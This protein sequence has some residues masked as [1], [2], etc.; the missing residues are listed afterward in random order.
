MLNYFIILIILMGNIFSIDNNNRKESILLIEINDQI[1]SLEIINKDKNLV[2]YYPLNK[3]LIDH[4]AYKVE[5]WNSSA[6]DNDI[7]NGIQFSN[8][9][10][11]YFHDDKPSKIADIKNNLEYLSYIDLV[12]YDYY[13][14]SNYIPNDPRYNNQWF[15][16]AINSN[17]A[18]DLWDINNNELP[19]DRS[20]ILASVDLGVNWQHQDLVENLWQNLNEDADGDGHTIEYIGGQWVLDPGDLNG[21]DD[22]NWDNNM[23]TF[24]D[25]LVGWDVTGTSYGDNDPDVPNNGSWAHGTHVAGLLAATTDNNTGIASTAFNS[26]IMSVKCTSE[27]DDPTYIYNGFDGI[28]YAAKAGYYSQGFSIINCSWGGVGYNLFE[29]EMISMCANEYNALIFAAA[30]N[31]N[32]EQAHYPSS[33]NDVISVT[34]LGQN[35]SWNHWATYHETVDL[36]SPGESIQSCV[37]NG[38]GY[39]SWNGTSMATPVAASVAGLM[40]SLYPNWNKEQIKTMIIATADPIIYEVNPESSIQGKL[41]S[42][43]VDALNAVITPLFP[44][45]ELTEIDLYIQNDYNNEINIGETIELIGIFLNNPEWGIATNPSITVSCNSNNI[46]VIN[47]FIELDNIPPGEATINFEPMIFEFDINIVPDLYECNIDFISNINSYI[48]YNKSFLI[49]FDVY[50]LP[51]L[52]GDI[53]Q[54]E[55]LDILDII[56]CVNIIIE[57]LEPTTYQSLASD[58]NEDGNTNIQDIILM[59]SLI[60]SI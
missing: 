34:A 21:I 48:E 41:G 53:N 42:G 5:R 10:R 23:S 43:R 37:N 3:F 13:R 1:E 29:Q 60:L 58:M 16:E 39:S 56:M 59:V 49:E 50:D 57:I 17:D 19:G 46:N 47:Q 35:N 12:E 2:D 32:I 54:D 44:K 22:D 4:G 30:G 45:I 7:Y 28:L 27:Q 55:T 33:Y 40:K 6:S 9:Y 36:A 20:I 52:L 51:I 14:K 24:I 11:L 38:S 15:L 18:W 25:D 8:I 26:S 31:E